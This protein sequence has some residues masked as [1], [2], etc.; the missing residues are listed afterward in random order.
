[1]LDNLVLTQR[2]YAIIIETKRMQDLAALVDSS[3]L[4]FFV[5]FAL[6]EKAIARLLRAATGFAYE[7][8]NSMR[9]GERIWN[10]ERLFNL[11]AGLTREDDTLP[12]RFLEQPLPQGGAKGQVVEL[13]PMLDEYYRVRGW[14]EHGVPG[15]DKLAELGLAGRK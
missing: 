10:L 2:S 6:S 13:T 11:Q 8:E 1:M 9:V 14:D 15:E 12:A 3:G 7:A 4:C 5:A